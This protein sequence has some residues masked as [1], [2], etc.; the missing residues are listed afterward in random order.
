[1]SN[2][3][4]FTL[5]R[6]RYWQGQKLLGRDF[7]DQRSYEA[8]S[9]WWH[10]RALHNAFG[11]AYGFEV[12]PISEEGEFTHVS[13]NCG[14]AY[15][16]FGRELIL[17]TTR[18]IALPRVAPEGDSAL[19]LVVNCKERGECEHEAREFSDCPSNC[20]CRRE[21]PEFQWEASRHSRF[22]DGVPL[23][24]ISYENEE[25]LPGAKRVPRFNTKFLPHFSRGFAKPRIGRGATVAGGTAWDPWI[26][27]VASQGG[28]RSQTQ[29]GVQVTIDTSTAGFT[30]TPCYFAWLQGSLWDKTNIEFFPVPISHIDN[31]SAFH[32]RFR[33]WMPPIIAVVGSRVRYAN[34]DP[35]SH[36]MAR[37]AHGFPNEF[38]NFARRQQL[39]VCWIG[40]QE[41]AQLTCEP[42]KDCEC[43]TVQGG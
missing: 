9:R 32:F 37:R 33:L 1:M 41:Q 42:V 26:E 38:L 29:I 35:L 30:Q 3:R 2:K 24:Q 12:T 43:K 40:I 4:P 21:G 5:E 7:R 28:R 34:L 16:C 20:S 19:T 23:A 39:Y 36:V 27:S 18:K 31:E 13:V 14:V 22:S 8:Q 25:N 15:D 6:L 11:V 17:Q 10:N